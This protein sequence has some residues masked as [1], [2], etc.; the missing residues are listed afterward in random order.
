MFCKSYDWSVLWSCDLD[1]VKAKQ[2]TPFPLLKEHTQ[3]RWKDC[4]CFACLFILPVYMVFW[5]QSNFCKVINQTANSVNSWF[6]IVRFSPR[7]FTVESFILQK[8]KIVLQ[9]T[10]KLGIERPLCDSS[11]DSLETVSFDIKL[12]QSHVIL[13]LLCYLSNYF[14]VNW[15]LW[16]ILL[17]NLYCI[18]SSYGRILVKN[19]YFHIF[20]AV[21]VTHIFSQSSIFSQILRLWR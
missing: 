7:Y 1:R 11:N 16:I 17:T 14:D 2:E 5:H 21:L 6:T 4:P 19:P 12:Y 15:C 20:Y 18:L 3:T 13:G 8:G 10:Q 9:K